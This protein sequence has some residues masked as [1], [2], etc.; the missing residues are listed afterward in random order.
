MRSGYLLMCAPLR[1]LRGRR[2]FFFGIS[3]V[4]LAASALFFASSA[5]AS[6]LADFSA[7]PASPGLSELI[8]NQNQLYQGP[9]AVGTNYPLW[10]WRRRISRVGAVC[11]RARH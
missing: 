9:G 11:G 10:P 2:A 3:C 6:T 4:L 5:A 7:V 8:W 1:S